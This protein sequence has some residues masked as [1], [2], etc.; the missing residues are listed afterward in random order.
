MDQDGIVCSPI[1][2]RSCGQLGKDWMEIAPARNGLERLQ[3][4]FR[5]HAYD[6]HRHD[7]YA[8]GVTLEGV[9]TFDCRRTTHYSLPGQVIVLH[10]DEP[11]NGRAGSVTGFGYR[12]L[13]LEPSRVREALD[14]LNLPFVPQMVFN[15]LI[16]ARAILAAFESFPRPLH[17]ME[18]DALIAR[19]ADHLVRRGDAKQKTQNFTAPQRLMDRVRAFL[20]AEFTR[21]VS[22]PE[23]ERLTGLS[24]YAI[25]RHFRVC[26]GTSPYRYLVMRRLA[27]AKRRIIQGMPIVTAAIELGFADQSHLTR[28]FHQMF[29]LPAGRLQRLCRRR[30]DETA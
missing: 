26:F 18:S 15:D 25:A 10:P 6:W 19:V 8:V 12:M 27:E 5:G 2:E 28:C 1:L 7:T 11:H 30:V 17:E 23:L 22:S 3:A 16:L 9:Q 14:V 29:G 20:D 4:R 24:R 21:P 13:Y